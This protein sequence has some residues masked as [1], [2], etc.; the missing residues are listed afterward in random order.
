[1]LVIEAWATFS[2]V[3]QMLLVKTL[4][5]VLVY[6]EEAKE[7]RKSKMTKSKTRSKKNKD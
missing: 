2:E 7:L 1:M 6:F 3:K 4:S 5:T